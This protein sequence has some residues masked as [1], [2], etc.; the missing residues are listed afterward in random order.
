MAFTDWGL[1]RALWVINNMAEKSKNPFENFAQQNPT[2]NYAGLAI[3]VGGL[4]GAMAANR[5]IQ[6]YEKATKDVQLRIGQVGVQAD[7]RQKEAQ[8]A[9]TADLAGY[10]STAEAGIKQGLINR[11]I[12]DK[13]VGESATSQFKSGMS[14]AYASAHAALAGAKLNAS[15]ALARTQIA[16]QQDLAQKQYASQLQK[17]YNNMGI[18]SAL[19]GIGA[20]ML[21][22]S[23]STPN[24]TADKQNEQAGEITSGQRTIAA[25]QEFRSGV[26]PDSSFRQGPGFRKTGMGA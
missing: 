16:Y 14:G 18:W 22:A 4:F 20:S 13:A 25:D 23:G 2:A 3:T 15:N 6:D 17:Y 12:T 24:P 5:S 8:A 21:G 26:S 7:T 10:Q 9:L 19:G 11:G 1:P